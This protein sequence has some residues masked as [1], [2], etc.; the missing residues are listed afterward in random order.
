ML[1]EKKTESQRI[2]ELE[3]IIERKDREIKEIKHSVADVLEKIR[4]LNESNDYGQPEI[5]KRRISEIC[6][7]TRYELLIDELRQN[8][9]TTQS[10]IK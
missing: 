10:Q 5:R 6:T 8:N 2:S 9:R 7:D 3:S 1:K 4:D